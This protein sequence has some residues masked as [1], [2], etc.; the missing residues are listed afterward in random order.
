MNAPLVLLASCFLLS[1][2]VR[3][4]FVRDPVRIDTGSDPFVGALTL[5]AGADRTVAVW[6]SSQPPYR[7]WASSSDGRGLQW[8]PPIRLD[9][10]PSGAF[11][12]PGTGP[13]TNWRTQNLEVRGNF[14]HV[15]WL[16]GRNATGPPSNDVYYARSVDGGASFSPEVRLDFGLVSGVGTVRR[17]ILKVSGDHVYVLGEIE[18]VTPVDDEEVWLV[19][20]TDS[21]VTFD[22]PRSVTPVNGTGPDVSYVSL[23]AEGAFVYV[24]WGD[25]RGGAGDDVYFA[26]S[27]DGGQSFIGDLKINS[28]SV[29]VGDVEAAAQVSVFGP[30]VMIAWLE[31]LGTGT[32][33][34]V[35]VAVST[36]GGASFGPDVQVGGYVPA[37][38]DA[39]SLWS[40]IVDG[41]LYVCWTDDRSGTRSAYVAT[42]DD[43]G[44]SWNEFFLGAGSRTPELVHASSN[45]LESPVAVHVR[46]PVFQRGS[47]SI[48]VTRD[49]GGTWELTPVSEGSMGPVSAGEAA[50][51]T[52]Y[53]NFHAIWNG[54]DALLGFDA[55]FAGGL[56]PQR[57]EPVG[58]TAGGAGSFELRGFRPSGADFGWVL[59]SNSPGAFP[60]PFGDGRDLGL[61]FDGLFLATLSDAALFVAL[62]PDGSGMTAPVPVPIVP[63]LTFQAA[64]VSFGLGPLEIVELTDRVEVTVP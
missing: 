59:G 5:A 27:V 56:R 13:A 63:G 62:A 40:D 10:D 6:T 52:R 22:A 9:S 53:G 11:K 8:S 1:G 33:E 12:Q 4:Q 16:D 49:Q 38:D 3:A 28:S 41:V 47:T 2:A 61:S 50:S 26:R 35:R 31:E 17:A 19:R 15:L 23:D 7:V 48:A 51:S 32:A 14:V 36:N 54:E 46:T 18:P 34:E 57:L 24:S 58:W 55:V 45:E 44:A 64:A 20:S 30:L 60:L 29:T 37:V 42:S 21:G 39:S 43:L 25:D